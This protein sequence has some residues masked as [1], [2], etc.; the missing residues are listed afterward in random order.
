[1]KSLFIDLFAGLGGA[2]QAF[3]Q[4]SNWDVLQFDN[5]VEL[6]PHNDQLII[7]D[8]LEFTDIYYQILRKIYIE[9]YDR[10][11]LWASPP[12]REFSTAY[13]GP[14][15]EAHRAGNVDY[16]P[17]MSCLM[18]SMRI[19][20]NLASVCLYNNIEFIWIVENVRGATQY[21]K[22][23]LGQWRQNIGSFFLWGNFPHITL[24]S[25]QRDHVKDDSRH[26]PIRANIKAKLPLEYSQAIKK[27]IE[28]QSKITS[29]Q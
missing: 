18:A 13:N 11:V 5:N 26:S 4:A 15:A 10:I 25:N 8:V 16:Q 24:M 1:M 20:D 19:R 28:G 12:C 27:A 2:S 22:P 23:F 17:D 9:D 3:C 29:Y 14:R 21:F 7:A 6:I